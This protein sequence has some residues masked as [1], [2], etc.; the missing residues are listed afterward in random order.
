MQKKST[1][2]V[3]YRLPDEWIS[4]LK[5]HCNLILHKKEGTIPSRRKF[6]ANSKKADGVLA[7]LNE[8]ID[9]D[10]FR[11]NPNLK[12]VANYAVGY[13]NID[14]KAAKKYNVAVSNTPGNLAGAVAEQAMLFIL[15]CSKRL[16]AGDKFMRAKKYKFWDPLLLLGHDVRGKTLGIVGTGRIGSQLAQMAVAGLGMKVKRFEEFQTKRIDLNRL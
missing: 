3:S 4:D 5:K 7:I 15:A 16:V 10:F 1:V 14:L 2:Y 13:D 12:I 8:K 6:L 9:E 11:T